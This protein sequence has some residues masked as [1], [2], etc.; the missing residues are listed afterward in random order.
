MYIVLFA[1]AIVS[2]ILTPLAPQ[3]VRLRIRFFRWLHWDWAVNVLEKHFGV[4]V[5]VF[6]IILLVIAALLLS[7][8][9][10]DLA[11]T[12]GPRSGVPL[13]RSSSG[14][15]EVR[16]LCRLRLSHRHGRDRRSLPA[17]RQR[18]HGTQRHEVDST[19]SR[20]IA[21]PSLPEGLRYVEFLP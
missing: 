20:G 7:A 19:G 14:P 18:P 3:L 10:E 17:Y 9:W 15:D 1:L 13:L 16:Y 5:L 2:L 11:E 21:A 6:R 12:K 8:G 4:W